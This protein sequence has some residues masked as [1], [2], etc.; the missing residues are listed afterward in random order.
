M[1][2]GEARQPVIRKIQL[3]NRLMVVTDLDKVD[4]NGASRLPMRTVSQSVV[5]DEDRLPADSSVS[6][7]SSH[8]H[9]KA[10]PSCAITPAPQSEFYLASQVS[11][12]NFNPWSNPNP[13]VT[14]LLKRK[15]DDISYADSFA[16]LM[17]QNTAP[18]S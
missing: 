9:T 16:F 13:L 2:Q 3:T 7:D 5:P 18:L 14:V 4:G 1:R 12:P 6:S 10:L 11:N 15:Y 8:L 17:F